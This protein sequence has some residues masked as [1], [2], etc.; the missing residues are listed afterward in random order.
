MTYTNAASQ[1]SMTSSRITGGSRFA[2]SNTGSSEV[3][4]TFSAYEFFIF[5]LLHGAVWNPYKPEPVR[6]F[7]QM[8]VSSI[9]FFSLE[10][11]IV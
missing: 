7:P 4:L 2:G 11:A 8:A 3:K 5:N 9:Q 6:T 10:F 1:R